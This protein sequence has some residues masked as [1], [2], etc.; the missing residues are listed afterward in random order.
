V[1]STAVPSTAVPSTAE[2]STAVPST[3]VPSTAVP[4]TAEPSTAVPSTAVPSTAVPSTAQPSTA[5]PSTA[6]PSTAVPSTAVPSTAVPPT[7]APLSE[8]RNATIVIALR[9]G[10][11]LTQGELGELQSALAAD[12]GSD[13]EVLFPT[14]QTDATTNLP[15]IS[16][17]VRRRTGS[18]S[19]ALQTASFAS[20]QALLERK[21]VKTSALSMCVACTEETLCDTDA[22]QDRCRAAAAQSS[23]RCGDG[24][25]AG[26]VIGLVGVTAVAMWVVVRKT[27]LRVGGETKEPVGSSA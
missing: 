12:F 15:Y 18:L 10:S 4:S 22:T 3:A 2:P 7:P 5:V 25:I 8:A 20:S 23:S 13:V 14:I 24:C 11:S 19:A 27:V 6:V 21:G 9:A 16:F 17:I 1:P 26:L